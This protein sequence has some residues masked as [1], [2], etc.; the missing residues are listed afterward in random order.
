MALVV[1]AIASGGVLRAARLERGQPTARPREFLPADAARVL[2]AW[3]RRVVVEGTGRSLSGH[4]I[5]IAGKTGTAEV[6]GA[7]SHAW[8]VGFAPA[9]GPG[10][11]AFAVVV[12]HAGYGSRAAAPAAG[13]IV[14]AA[15]AS[16]LLR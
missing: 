16:G 4:P 9:D 7:P 8:F 2:G 1:A 11:I 10:R 13:A 3:M 6:A 15:A 12:E 5:A 14:S